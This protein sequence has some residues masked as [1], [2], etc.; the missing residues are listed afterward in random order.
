MPRGAG[1]WGPRAPDRSCCACLTRSAE[2]LRRT[3]VGRCCPVPVC[4]PELVTSVPCLWAPGPSPDLGH[5]PRQEVRGARETVPE[6]RGWEWGAGGVLTFG[7]TVLEGGG[8]L[9][10]GEQAPSTGEAACAPRFRLVGAHGAGLA[11][12]EAVSGEGPWRALA[13]K[14]EVTAQAGRGAPHSGPALCSALSCPG[15]AEGSGQ[16]AARL[17]EGEEHMVWPWP[18]LASLL[19]PAGRAVG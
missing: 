7:L 10:L 19:L 2:T 16:R 17:G 3:W 18:G 11:G 13:W 8:A 1:A 6:Q 12:P 4:S 15:K 5:L 9:V 14:S